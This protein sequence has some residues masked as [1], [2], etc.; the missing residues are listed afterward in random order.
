M[1]HSHLR[2]T[3][4]ALAVASLSLALTPAFP[5][6]IGGPAAPA[7]QALA[8]HGDVVTITVANPTATPVR[9][10][11]TLR[12]A[13]AEGASVLAVPVTVGP[14]A[15]TTASVGA[16]AP[17]VGVLPLGVVLDDGVPF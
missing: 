2:I 11:V 17:I 12:V 3:H 14:Q 9:A 16:S 13:T 6:S 4:A 5:A 15:T 7:I 8:V 10:T 1:R